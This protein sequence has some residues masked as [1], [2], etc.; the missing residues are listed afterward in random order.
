MGNDPDQNT[1][2]WHTAVLFS[3]LTLAFGAG[4]IQ[5]ARAGDEGPP[6]AY[7]QGLTPQKMNRHFDALLAWAAGEL[8][9]HGGEGVFADHP[10]EKAVI[11]EMLVLA[12]HLMEQSRQAKAQG[13]AARARALAY[14]AEATA[15]YA[16]RMP[17]LLEDRLE[18]D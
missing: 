10:G 5:S 18:K 14:S 8:A 1:T 6:L 16:A 12:R 2:S 4:A 7:L 15:R 3:C 13:D 17:H 9:E 11:E